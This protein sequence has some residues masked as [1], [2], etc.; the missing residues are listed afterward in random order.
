MPTE[1]EVR[2][3]MDD[4]EKSIENLSSGFENLRTDAPN[5]DAPGTQSPGTD[6]PGTNP[7]GTQTP[8]TK[9]PGTD[10]PGTSAPSTEAPAE[11]PR[12]AELRKLREENEELKRAKT[13]KAPPTKAPPTKAPSTD[14]PIAEIDFLGDTDLDEL[15][16]D[17]KLFNQLLNKVHKSGVD[18]GRQYAKTSSES[19]VR[20][21]PDIVKNNITITSKLKEAN[22]QFYK[23]NED[24]IPWKGAVAT[25]F[26]EEMAKDPSKRYDEILPTVADEVRR[27]IGLKKGGNKKED[28]PPPNL[29]GRKKG[30]QRQ[31]LKPDLSTFEKEIDEMDKALD[32]Y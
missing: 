3:E 17:P 10:A 30:S 27:R 29:P 8:G 19:V 13:T 25:V 28:D 11:D 4:M 9:A 5:T 7:P 31:Q 24:L 26:Q 23:D 14:A 21:I 1:E 6:P 15:T 18:L 32:N 20:S 2:K 16:R 22:E 12:D